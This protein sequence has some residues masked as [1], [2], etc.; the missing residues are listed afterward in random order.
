[1][2]VTKRKAAAE[3]EKNHPADAE[4]DAMKVEKDE[5]R[6]EK[7]ITAAV[8][9]KEVSDL[10]QCPAAPAVVKKNQ[11]KVMDKKGVLLGRTPFCST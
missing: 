1:M 10:F 5:M 8:E 4:R 7:M 9:E 6:A 2:A 11:I 3:R